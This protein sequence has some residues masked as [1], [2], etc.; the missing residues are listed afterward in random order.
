MLLQMH[1]KGTVVPELTAVQ[2]VCRTLGIGLAPVYLHGMTASYR[3]NLCVARPGVFFLP[4]L[5]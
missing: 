1:N 5:H 2:P 4:L 3:T